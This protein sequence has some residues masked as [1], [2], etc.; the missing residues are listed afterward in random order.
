M[1]PYLTE[2][3]IWNHI[4]FEQNPRKCSSLSLFLSLEEE[5]DVSN[6]KR[7]LH[8]V[9]KLERTFGLINLI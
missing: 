7:G 1:I 9:T 5:T 6:V 3:Y 2:N 8:V 4:S